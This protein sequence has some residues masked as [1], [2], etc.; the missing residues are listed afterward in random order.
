MIP[1]RAQS[2]CKRFQLS[3]GAHFICDGVSGRH[4]IAIGVKPIESICRRRCS[5]RS[6]V[7][8]G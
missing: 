7:S 3:S 5:A 1:G 4:S 2:R 6:N 8:F